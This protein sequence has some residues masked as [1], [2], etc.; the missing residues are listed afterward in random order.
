MERQ[1]VCTADDRHLVRV[2]LAAVSARHDVMH[3][4]KPVI[5]ASFDYTVPVVPAHHLPPDGRGDGLRRA[6]GTLSR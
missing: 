4:E 3:V 2:V 6:T 1:V 5:A